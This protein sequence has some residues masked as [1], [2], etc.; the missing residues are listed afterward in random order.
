MKRVES[1]KN[2]SIIFLSLMVLIRG[3]WIILWRASQNNIEVGDI[4]MLRPAQ[5]IIHR[6]IN[7]QN[8]REKFLSDQG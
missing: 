3:T 4:L 6:A 5:P 1:L 7:V 8:R 2:S